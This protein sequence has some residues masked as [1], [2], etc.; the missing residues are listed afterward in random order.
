MGANHSTYNEFSHE[1]LRNFEKH[2]KLLKDLN[3]PRFGLIQIF[4]EK[5]ANQGPSDYV[6]L[7]NRLLNGEDELNEFHREVKLRSKLDH[8]NLLK[9]Y[10]YH[11]EAKEN[12]CGFTNKMTVYSEW[13][14]HDLETELQRRAKHE[15]RTNK[16]IFR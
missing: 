1:S 9:I 15:V 16:K 6:M 5:A 11:K 10:G 8:P 12:L 4:K 3:D 13:H 7:S 14:E 2:F